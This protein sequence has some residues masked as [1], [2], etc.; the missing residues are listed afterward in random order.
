MHEFY[1][2]EDI[3]Y[4]GHLESFKHGIIPPQCVGKMLSNKTFSET[5]IQWLLDGLIFV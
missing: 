1:T 3:V 5:R 4:E 2:T